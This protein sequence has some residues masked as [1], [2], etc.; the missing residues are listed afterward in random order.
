VNFS[1]ELFVNQGLVGAGRVSASAID[2][3]GDTLGSFSGMAL[4]LTTW[5]RGP[6]GYSGVLY[7]LPDR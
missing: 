5:R 3:N 4:D 1:G 7:T 2:F 6:S